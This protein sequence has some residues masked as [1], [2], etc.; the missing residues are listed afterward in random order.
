M[1]VKM[2]SLIFIFSISYN[3]NIIVKKYLDRY[4]KLIKQSNLTST[5]VNLK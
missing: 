3:L 1:L 4:S 5:H 2:T